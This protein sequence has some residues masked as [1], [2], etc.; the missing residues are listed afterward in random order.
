MIIESP[1]NLPLNPPPSTD[2]RW[3]IILGTIIT[4]SATVLPLVFIVLPVNR[5]T[6]SLLS[7]L[8]KGEVAS[9]QTPPSNLNF[10]ETINLAQNYLNKAYE[11]A[12][13]QNQTEDDKKAIF[14]SLNESLKQV[15]SAI[16]LSPRNPTGYL[17]RAQIFTTISKVNPDAVALAKQ[18]LDVAQQLSSGKDVSL[19]PAVNPIN[20]LPEEQAASISS[21]LIASPQEEST[22]SGELDTQTNA[23][24]K[25]VVLP[26][27]QI[28]IVVNDPLVKPDSYIYLLPVTATNNPVYV[29]TKTDGSFTIATTSPS[30]SNQAIDYYL[31]NE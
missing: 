23:S 26:A 27:N 30:T 9:A 21:F 29:K 11:L 4:L 7:P 2:Y 19:P 13:N 1:I 3:P 22:A 24:Q 10:A 6:G 5:P 20:L 31:I 15:T 16:N 25:R 8:P 17:L 18:D 12:R 14:T 28:E